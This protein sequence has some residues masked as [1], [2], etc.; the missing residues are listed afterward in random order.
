M[1]N[2]DIQLNTSRL[3]RA[4]VNGD[5]SEVMKLISEGEDVNA[6]NK[7]GQTALM[8]ASFI[9]ESNVNIL[10]ALLDAGADVNDK[11][12]NGTTAL[13]YASMPEQDGVEDNVRFLIERGADVNSRNNYGT[14]ALMNT[15]GEE[16]NEN[17]VRF[18]IAAGAYVNLQ[19]NYGKTALIDASEYGNENIVQ[20][21]IS[22]GADIDTQD[23][24]GV[25][26]LIYASLNGHKNVVIRL[27]NAG[28]DISTENLINFKGRKKIEKMWKEEQNKYL[29]R[30]AI[31]AYMS[32]RKN[33]Y[34]PPTAESP[35]SG[36][37][38]RVD[39]ADYIMEQILNMRYG[40]DAGYKRK[41]SGNKR[42]KSR[43]RK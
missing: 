32:S 10:K 33:K 21:L 15:S 16:G 11:A 19:N 24:Q 34:T 8:Y 26:A 29:K 27:I 39:N 28:A 43:S 37:Y 25:N 22:A 31:N 35:S 12:I 20:L 14:T 40:D 36:F 13:M 4:S 23:N 18:L 7:L 30:V 41:K 1:E 2:L 3:M 38:H 42:R 5:Y 6:K 9:G 17:S